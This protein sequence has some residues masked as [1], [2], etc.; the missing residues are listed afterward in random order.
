MRNLVDKLIAKA[1]DGDVQAIKELLDRVDGRRWPATM[2]NG[3]GCF[4]AGHEVADVPAFVRWH[5][6]CTK[7]TR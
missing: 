3:T 4:S 2:T 1:I 6:T 5:A 7:G